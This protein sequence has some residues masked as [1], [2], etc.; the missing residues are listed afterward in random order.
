MDTIQPATASV[1][2]SIFC[3]GR[4]AQ[5]PT[6]PHVTG[7]SPNMGK[8]LSQTCKK[9]LLQSHHPPLQIQKVTQSL[10]GER[11]DARRQQV[12]PT[13][14]P[15]S[16]AWAFPQPPPSPMP[17]LEASASSLHALPRKCKQASRRGHAVTLKTLTENHVSHNKMNSNPVC[18]WITDPGK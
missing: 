7:N 2:I 5:P 11:A 9:G 16:S 10:R 6:K 4:L 14:P 17:H 1:C 12:P 18:L 8:G 13:S 3:T 15:L